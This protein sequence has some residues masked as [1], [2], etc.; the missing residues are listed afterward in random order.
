MI[1]TLRGAVWAGKMS[2]WAVGI[3]L[4]GAAAAVATGGVTR[5]GGPPVERDTPFCIGSVSKL[6]TAITCLRLHETGVLELDTPVVEIVPD[7][8]FEDERGSSVTTSHLLSHCSG[9]PAAGRD[10]GPQSE[11]ALARFARED[12]ATHQFHADPGTVGRYSSSAFSLSGMILESLAHRPFAE[13]VAREV[14]APAGMGHTRWPGGSPPDGL[15][16]PVERD[17]ESFAPAARL[18]DNPS[19][20]PGGFLLAPIDDLIRLALTLLTEELLTTESQESMT[21][22]HMSRHIDQAPS[23]LA[24]ASAGFGLGCFTG[25]WNGQPIFRH[26]GMQQSFNC[27]FDLFPESESAFIL[28]TNGMEEGTFND[29][30]A[31]GFE[32]AGGQTPDALPLT[33]VPYDSGSPL[34]AT[35]TFVD[36][37]SGRLVELEGEDSQLVMTEGAVTEELAHV[38]G[39][40]YLGYESQSPVWIPPEA[41]PIPYLTIWGT[42]FFRTHLE[43]WPAGDGSHFTGGYVDSFWPDRSTDIDVTFQDGEWVVSRDGREASGR[44]LAPRRLA[45]EHGLVDFSPD[46]SSLRLGRATRFVRS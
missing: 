2:A 20:Y 19:G 42:P 6:L 13:V 28:L 43:A 40:R 46:G 45:T 25:N 8:H 27:S 22:A 37:D 5:P 4:D 7:L 41:D 3:V 12:L 29:I 34:R 26:D 18:A 10:W 9:L 31:L 36:A 11:D 16:W 30:L 21:A 1:D 24:R 23:V 17:G 33:L 35:G 44:P 38:G 15:V 39:S 32:A 14:L